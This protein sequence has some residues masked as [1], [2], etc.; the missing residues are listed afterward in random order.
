MINLSLG[1]AVLQPD[2]EGRDRPRRRGGRAGGGGRRQRPR[3]SVRFPADQS[4]VIAVGA[5][6]RRQAAGRLLELRPRA[7]PRG[8]R[9][10]LR[11]RRR[12]RRHGRLHVAAD[13]AIR[14]GRSRAATTTSATSA[15]RAPAWRRPTWRPPRRSSISQGFTDVASVRAALEQTA[16]RLGGAPAGGRND[17]FGNGLIR[18]AAA[19]PGYGFNVSSK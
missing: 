1:S 8:A 6:E 4:N 11:A 5:A 3:G 7:R 9:R 12:P 14:G 16:E 2:G 13:A 10:R 17:T 19:L 18:P 15:S